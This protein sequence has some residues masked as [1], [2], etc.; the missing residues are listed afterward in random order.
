MFARRVLQA[1]L[2]E[3]EPHISLEGREKL[4]RELNRQSRSTLGFE[5]VAL[6]F[7]LS[8]IGKVEYEAGSSGGSNLKTAKAL[9]L[10]V[11]PSILLRAD[12]VIE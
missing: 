1:M 10:A 2:Y 7:G 6:L 3:V 9:G 4:A 12:E 8:R 11:P 5:W